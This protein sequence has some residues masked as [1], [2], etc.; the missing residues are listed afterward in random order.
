MSLVD[1]I[2]PESVEPVGSMKEANDDNGGIS[3]VS[4]TIEPSISSFKSEQ[5]HSPFFSLNTSYDQLSDEH[6]QP[7]NTIQVFTS[8]LLDQVNVQDSNAVL[9]AQRQM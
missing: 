3:V 5:T 2:S 6:R 1:A 8:L 4:N 9:D 7:T